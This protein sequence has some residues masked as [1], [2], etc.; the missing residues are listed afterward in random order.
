MKH[1]ILFVTFALVTDAAIAA[2][3]LSCREDLNTK[4][5]VCYER[6]TVRANGELRSF[7]MATGGPKGVEK[8]PYLGV[9]NCRAKYLELRDRKGVVFARNVPKK[10]HIRYLIADICEEPKPKPDKSLD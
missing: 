8:S 5:T 6:K 4:A 7:T 10:A 1:V 9:V 3:P 2:L